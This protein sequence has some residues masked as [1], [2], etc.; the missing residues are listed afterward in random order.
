MDKRKRENLIINLLGCFLIYFSSC[1]IGAF[2]L[3]FHL[4][5]DGILTFNPNSGY[6]TIMLLVGSGSIL[7]LGIFLT[8]I[9]YKDKKNR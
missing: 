2:M 7:T 1:L 8:I 6:P 9:K 5:E 4:V 3:G